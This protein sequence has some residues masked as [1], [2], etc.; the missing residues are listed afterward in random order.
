MGQGKEHTFIHKSSIRSNAT[1]TRYDQ[2][3]Q[4][5]LP[6]DIPTLEACTTKNFTRVNNVFCSA[7]LYDHFDSCNMF[8]QWRPQKTDHMPIISVLEIEPERIV[9]VKK[10]NYKLTDWEEFRKTLANELAD[11]QGTEELTLVE[12]FEEQIKK[13]DSAIKTAIK[14]HIPVMKPSPYMKR[15]WTKGLADIKRCKEWLARKSYRRRDV[16]EDPIHEEFRQAQNNYLMA[17]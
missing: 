1:F 17:I 13:L 15:W 10:H 11:L 12:E 8:P 6:K 2:Q 9:Q 5:A 7:E 3:M 14:E 4:M 16:D